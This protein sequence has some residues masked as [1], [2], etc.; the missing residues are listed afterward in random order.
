MVYQPDKVDG[1]NL[2]VIYLLD[3][4]KEIKKEQAIIADDQEF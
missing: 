2:K 4:F 3:F 1:L